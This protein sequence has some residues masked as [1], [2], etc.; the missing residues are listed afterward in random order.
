MADELIFPEI[1]YSININNMSES[2][3]AYKRL[4]LE[5]GEHRAD[6]DFKEPEYV[7]A[8]KRLRRDR[9]TRKANLKLFKKRSALLGITHRI[10]SA[11]SEKAKTKK[12]WQAKAKARFE[13]PARKN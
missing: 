3:S 7:K 8:V 11:D 9:K 2:K 1:K 12:F 5:L 10:H 6:D 4:I 13:G